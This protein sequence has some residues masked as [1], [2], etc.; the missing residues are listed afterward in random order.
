MKFR[1]YVV[2]HRPARRPRKGAWIEIWKCRMRLNVFT[3][4]PPQGGV[5]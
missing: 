5:D 4:S 1:V 2:N 3:L